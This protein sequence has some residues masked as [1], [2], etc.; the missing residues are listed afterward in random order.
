MLAPFKNIKRGW[1]NDVVID[2]T[3]LYLNILGYGK[4]GTK[5]FVATK[6]K[7][8][9]KPKWWDDANNFEKYSHPSKAKMRVNEDII[10]SILR[11]HGYDPLTHCENP[12]P[13][14]KERRSQ[15]SLKKNKKR[16]LGESLLED[17]PAI[18]DL[19][20]DSNDNNEKTNE[21]S[22]DDESED[23]WE[24]VNEKTDYDVPR[25]KT[26][27]QLANLKLSWF[28]ENVIRKNIE[29]RKE[30]AKKLGIDDI[31]EELRKTAKDYVSTQSD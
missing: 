2:Q 21:D 26:K 25:K 8:A 23:D 31:A 11:Y 27:K 10:E 9:E 28:E 12:D 29:E 4:G 17:D 3:T 6:L 19:R 16:I 1:N 13:E 7:K 5:S 20:V 24:D 22:T 30:L 15:K 18:L 14:P